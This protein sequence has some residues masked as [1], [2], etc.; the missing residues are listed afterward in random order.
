MPDETILEIVREVLRVYEKPDDVPVAPDSTIARLR[1]WY[2]EASQPGRKE[3]ENMTPEERAA[4]E[5]EEELGFRLRRCEEPDC[6][7][8]DAVHKRGVH[9]HWP[10]AS[11][12][13]WSLALRQRVELN[14]LNESK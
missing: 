3:N 13:L 6:I 9:V 8:V 14:K 10:R 1:Q 12:A 7:F 4:S 5:L 11:L 2:D